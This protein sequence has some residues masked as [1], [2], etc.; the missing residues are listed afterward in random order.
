VAAVLLL[1]DPSATLRAVHRSPL[2]SLCLLRGGR[3]SFT[4]SQPQPPCHS[5][6]TCCAC[7]LPSLIIQS[8][9]LQAY[10]VMPR[11]HLHHRSPSSLPCKIH[12]AQT[13]AEGRNPLP[14]H[15]SSNWFKFIITY[16]HSVSKRIQF[17]HVVR[18]SHV[19]NKLAHNKKN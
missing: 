6:L 14:I 7:R 18:F 17:L 16:T 13:V 9:V 19:H 12:S 1:L 11:G 3:L 4:K 15:D 10:R 2:Y 8:T 5:M